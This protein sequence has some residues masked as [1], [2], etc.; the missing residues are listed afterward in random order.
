[1]GSAGD[2]GHHGCMITRAPT[3]QSPAGFQPFSYVQTDIPSRVTI[4]EYRRAR[5]RVRELRRHGHTRFLR[6]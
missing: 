5:P 2:R 4:D 6:A 3:F 1:M